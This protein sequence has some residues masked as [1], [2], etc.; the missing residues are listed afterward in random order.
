MV[1]VCV[2]QTDNRPNLNYLLLTKE[3]NKKF[4]KLLGYNYLFIEIDNYKYKNLHPATKKIFIVNDFLQNSNDDILIFLDSDAWIQDGTWLNTIVMNLVNSQKQGAF[5]R[6]PYIKRNTYIN[7]GSFILKINQLT[8]KM[9]SI[10]INH[11][12]LNTKYYNSWP[13]DQYYIS[14]FVYKNRDKFVIFVPD[15]LNTPIGKVLRHN[16]EKNEK[17]YKDIEEVNHK[18]NNNFWVNY[19]PFLENEYYCNECFPN[20]NEEGYYYTN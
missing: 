12:N 15:I 18:L 4:C 10:I 8:K 7:S 2:V 9:Y 11:L 19:T 1:N 13:F 17:M 14:D 20:I 16:W 5:S 6:D 3:I